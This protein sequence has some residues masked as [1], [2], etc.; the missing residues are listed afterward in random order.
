MPT[1]FLAVNCRVH[2]IPLTSKAVVRGTQVTRD[3]KPV[4]LSAREFQLLRYFVEHAGTTLSRDEFL[5]EVWGYEGGTFT[6]AVDVDVAG[7]RQNLEKDPNRPELILTVSGIGYKLLR[8][9]LLGYTVVRS[10]FVDQGK[11]AW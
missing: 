2:H 8:E 9:R 3:G 1:G 10:S 11:A 4:Y 6:R 5:R 7:L